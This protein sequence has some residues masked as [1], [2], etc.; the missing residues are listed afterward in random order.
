MFSQTAE[1]ALRAVVFIAEGPEKR[2]TT[3]AIADTTRIPPRYLAKVLNSLARSGVLIGQRGLN[4]GFTL[5]RSPA[6][7]SVLQVIE[8]VDPL[9]RIYKCPLNLEAHRDQL[10]PLH[11]RLDASMAMIQADLQ[12]SFIADLLIRPTFR[13]VG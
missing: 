6:E 11:S 4:G 2:Y 8:A 12:Q 10:C 13:K 7:I 9:K 1:Y 5:S 3:Q